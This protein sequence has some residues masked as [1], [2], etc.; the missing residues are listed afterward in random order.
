M[1]KWKIKRG[2]MYYANLN[3]TVGSEQGD[4]RPVLVV[5]NNAGNSHSPTT[6]IVPI[7]RNLNKTSLPTHVGIPRESGLDS[8]SLALCEQIRT[9]D[10]SRMTSYIGHISGEVQAEIDDALLVCVG[11]EKHRAVKG[12]MMVLSLCPRCE[13]D[14]RDRGYVP[15]KKGWQEVKENCDFC[16]VRQGLTFGVFGSL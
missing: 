16:K 12:E 1:S 7:T 8:D 13:S 10:C 14:F 3:P 6:V 2:D 11:I 15:M 5:Q 9:V 4:F